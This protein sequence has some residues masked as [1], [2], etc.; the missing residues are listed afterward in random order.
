MYGRKRWVL[1]APGQSANVYY[2]QRRD[3]PVIFS[4]VDMSDPD[5][6]RFPR[7][8]SA[9]RHDFVLEAGEVLYLPPGWWHYVESLSDSINVNYWWWS[10]AP[11][12]PSAGSARELWQA[13]ARRWGRAAARPA[14]RCRCRADAPAPRRSPIAAGGRVSS[15]SHDA[16]R[17]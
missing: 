4:P 2:R 14:S 3:L 13:L 9:P 17:V 10:P 16:E 12:G 11:C 5:P 7:V 15:G 6:V 8:Q 1:F